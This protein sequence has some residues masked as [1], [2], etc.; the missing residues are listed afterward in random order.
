MAVGAFP[1]LLLFFD[2]GR[3]G[4]GQENLGGLLD[5]LSPDLVPPENFVGLDAEGL[6]S[7]ARSTPRV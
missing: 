1:R 5:D 6:M 7:L 3:V 2:L 4:D